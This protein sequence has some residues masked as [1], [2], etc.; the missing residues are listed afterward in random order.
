MTSTWSPS[1]WR[2]KPIA[3]V[4]HAVAAPAIA[5]ES[6]LIEAAGC[7]LRGQSPP[8]EGARQ[9]AST[10]TSSIPR[11]GEYHLAG[12]SIMTAMSMLISPSSRST[13]S[14]ASSRTWRLGRRSSFREGTAPSSLMTAHRWASM[15]T[16]NGCRLRLAGRDTNRGMC[17]LLLLPH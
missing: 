15:W 13:G 11:G 12:R 14:G 7:H 6:S 2:D 8:R 10:T 4:R 5:A 9:T 1:S 3:Q 17:P 16:R